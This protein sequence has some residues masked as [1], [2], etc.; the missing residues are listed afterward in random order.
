MPPAIC[1]C[2][3]G[4]NI[5]FCIKVLHR[6]SSCFLLH[7]LCI[8]KAVKAWNIFHSI[9]KMQQSF[10][11]EK[12]RKKPQ[13]LKKYSNRTGTQKTPAAVFR[14]PRILCPPLSEYPYMG[15]SN[16]KPVLYLNQ[17][18][19]NGYTNPVNINQNYFNGQSIRSGIKRSGSAGQCRSGQAYGITLVFEYSMEAGVCQEPACL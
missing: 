16:P 9:T 7:T 2:P 15:S 8:K 18:R 12:E 5:F 4:L 1:T 14:R 13:L 17:T 10:C 6:V 11:P 19:L 3:G